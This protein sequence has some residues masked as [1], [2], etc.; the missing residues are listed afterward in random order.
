MENKTQ[1]INGGKVYYEV[2]GQVS[3]AVN[4]FIQGRIHSLGLPSDLETEVLDLPRKRESKD[5][6]RPTLSFLIYRA[7]GGQESLEQLTPVLSVS[8]LNNY[9]CY[10]DNWILDNKNN[11]GQNL[12]KTR[13]VTIAS[14]IL[15]DLTQKVIEETSI[16]D[17]KKRNISGRLAETTL[18][19]YEGQFRDLQM[20]TETLGEYPTEESYLIAYIEKSRLQSGYLY[21]LS[22]EIGAILAGEKEEGI[23]LARELSDTLGTGIHMSNDLGDFTIFREQDGSFKPYQDQLADIINGRITFP[24]YY[25][26]T[27]GTEEE[28]ATI[29]GIVGKKDATNEE[30]LKVSRVILD[31]GA[32][33]ATRK[34]LNLQYHQFKRLVRQLSE[35]PERSALSSIGKIIR[36]NKYLSEFKK[37]KPIT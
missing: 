22:G 33:D 27:H 5:I 19:C 14:Q 7:Y 11:I 3:I 32:Y 9:Y 36:Y 20:T 34:I 21:G 2:M 10:L 28:K 31:S 12:D 17:E 1:K 16:S 29:K 13:R 18:K 8:E 37:L 15:R 23:R 26:L 25:V 30:K 4:R 6:M 35:T 24:A